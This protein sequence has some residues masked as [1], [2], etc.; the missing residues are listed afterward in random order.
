[1]RERGLHRSG[2]T[3]FSAAAYRWRLN[4]ASV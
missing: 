3:R 2:D 4:V 1:L